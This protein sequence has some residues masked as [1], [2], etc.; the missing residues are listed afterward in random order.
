M[1]AVREAGREEAGCGSGSGS[2]D[3]GDDE[4]GELDEEDCDP[5]HDSTDPRKELYSVERLGKP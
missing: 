4:E 5:N 2:G 1:G 3:G